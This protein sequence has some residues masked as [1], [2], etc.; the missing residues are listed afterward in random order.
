MKK[1][2]SSLLFIIFCL[3][4]AYQLIN[5]I[6]NF[7]YGTFEGAVYSFALFVIW[8]GLSIWQYRKIKK[9]AKKPIIVTRETR[10]KM[11]AKD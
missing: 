8:T 7:K 1:E 11:R 10:K 9:E 6:G 5:V 2:T 3:F 4:A